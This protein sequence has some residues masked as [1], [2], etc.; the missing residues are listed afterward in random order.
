ME[1]A[2]MKCAARVALVGALTIGA[3]ETTNYPDIS[4]ELTKAAIQTGVAIVQS[5]FGL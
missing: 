4:Q 5:L 2:A 1:R 3:M